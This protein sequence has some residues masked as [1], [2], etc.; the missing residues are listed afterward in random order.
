[1]PQQLH[2]CSRRLKTYLKIFGHSAWKNPA[3]LSCQK[4][5]IN[6]G[7]YSLIGICFLLDWLMVQPG[8]NNTMMNHNLW[9]AYYKHNRDSDK[10]NIIPPGHAFLN[11]SQDKRT[12][13]E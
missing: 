1:M 13:F 9:K 8:G 11:E 10:G 12:L 5:Q 7:R 6:S 3:F 4:L 2:F